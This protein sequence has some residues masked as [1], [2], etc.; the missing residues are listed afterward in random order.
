MNPDANS[1]VSPVRSQMWE[2]R[3][4]AEVEP[5]FSEEFT[6]EHVT[7]QLA[8]RA[9]GVRGALA[10]RADEARS[11]EVLKTFHLV[12]DAEAETE[13]QLNAAK[14]DVKIRVAMD[15]GACKSV[16]HLS[17]MPSGVVITPSTSGRHVLGAG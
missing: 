17:V 7:K 12:E 5:I 16:A 10:A 9:R 15:S 8:R 13:D 3:S 6:R 2:T 14:A 1:D 4:V 11:A